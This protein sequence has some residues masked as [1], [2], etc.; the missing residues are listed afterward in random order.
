[1]QHPLREI[2]GTS[3]SP[4]WVRELVLVIEQTF[5]TLPKLKEL[6]VAVTAGIGLQGIPMVQ[7]REGALAELFELAAQGTFQNALALVSPHGDILR[8]EITALKELQAQAKPLQSRL[9]RIYEPTV[10]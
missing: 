7:S 10:F 9:N 3:W 5:E 4:N 8:A 1:M 2:R 6:L